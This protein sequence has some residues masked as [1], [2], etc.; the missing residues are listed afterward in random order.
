M[1][2][3]LTVLSGP[4]DRCASTAPVMGEVLC[5]ESHFSIASA[6][7][8][9]TLLTTGPSVESLQ[10]WLW[11]KDGQS[12]STLETCFAIKISAPSMAPATPDAHRWNHLPPGPVEGTWQAI[13]GETEKARIQS[14]RFSEILSS[15][16]SIIAFQAETRFLDEI[17]IFDNLVNSAAG[18][19]FRDVCVSR[20]KLR[21]YI[22]QRKGSPLLYLRPGVDDES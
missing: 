14:A 17:L 1:Q 3:C 19:E 7:E 9:G 16:C 11:D 4:P 21:R 10:D 5:I 13:G 2:S 15:R 18:V 22:Q 20:K 6:V 8:T 12:L